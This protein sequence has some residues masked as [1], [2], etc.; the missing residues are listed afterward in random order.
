[1]SL[2]RRFGTILGIA[3]VVAACGAG[4]GATS[5][6]GARSVPPAASQAPAEGSPAAQPPAATP[7]AAATQAAGGGSGTVC[8]LVTAA[9]LEAILGL[10]PV[11]TQVIAGP[12]DTCD[13]QV[14][15]APTAAMVLTTTNGKMVFDLLA[16]GADAQKLDGIGDGAFY[17]SATQLVV[18]K[19]G[20]AMVSVAV[21]DVNVT[22]DK[23]IAAQKAIAAKAASRL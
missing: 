6:V 19:K 11:V 1:V 7:T 15:N 17:S 20:D 14:D 9:E 2:I 16:A 4:S 10:S 18:F 22:D 23:R 13:I 5:S 8:D 3:I 12:P 21:T